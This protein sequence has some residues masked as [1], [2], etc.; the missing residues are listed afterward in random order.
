MFY[1]KNVYKGVKLFKEGQNSIQD[2]DRPG[3]LRMKSM[4]KMVDSVNALILV[5]WRVTIEN[6]SE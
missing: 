1:S 3:R 2:E 4:S 6:I 5:D